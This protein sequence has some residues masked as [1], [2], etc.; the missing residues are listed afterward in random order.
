LSLDLYTRFVVALVAILAL[1][2]VFAWLVRRYGVGGRPAA[3]AKRRLAIVE[4]APIDGKRRLVLLR[5]DDT[6][7]LVLLGPENALLVESGIAVP[8]RSEPSFAA[9]VEGPQS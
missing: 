7:H 6:E 1:L 4:V 9:M 3:G 5:R 2:A 8:S